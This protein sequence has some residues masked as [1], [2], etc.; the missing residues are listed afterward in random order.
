MGVKIQLLRASASEWTSKN[1]T[2][3]AGQPGF[4]IDTFK[5][6]I[7]NGVL[8]WN[9]LPYISGGFGGN[10]G[11]LEYEYDVTMY[12]DSTTTPSELYFNSLCNNIDFSSYFDDL[13]NNQY[14]VNLKVTSVN[15]SNTFLIA[16]CDNITKNSQF[17]DIDAF[18][19]SRSIKWIIDGGD[20]QYDSA[21]YINTNYT[22]SG[23]PTGS[24]S[25]TTLRNIS[26]P[27]NGGR[28][29]EQSQYWGS[30]DYVTLYKKSIWAMVAKGNTAT[31]P[32]TV[33]YG[34]NAGA[35]GDGDKDNGT[36]TNYNGY[37]A[38]YARLYG[39]D[40]T[41]TKLIITKTGTTPSYFI[42]NAND[43]ND[44]FFGASGISSDTIAVVVFY[45]S[46]NVNPSSLSDLQILFENFVDNVLSG[47]VVSQIK[48]NFYNNF[49]T[50]YGSVD[51][52]FWYENFEF[53]TGTNN[54]SAN[55][56]NS[57]GGSGSGASFEVLVNQ[58][59]NKYDITISVA[60][61]N[62][63]VDDIIK[64][65]GSG[66]GSPNGISPDEDIYIKVNS[67]DIN[68]GVDTF[69]TII[70]NEYG[71]INLTRLAES[72]GFR[73]FDNEKFYLNIDVAGLSLDII[74]TQIQDAF[75][76]SVVAGD[77]INLDYD[78]GNQTLTIEST[79]NTKILP[80]D[81]IIFDYDSG[82]DELT[83]KASNI[84]VP[85]LEDIL[86]E[87]IGVD[88][89]FDEEANT[90]TINNLHTEI[91]EL[92]K[93]PQGFVN[94]T[95][96]VITFDD[97][98]RTF[99]I[100]PTVSGGSYEIYIEGVKVVKNTIETIVLG[101]STALNYI[102]FDT[103]T[104]ALQTKTTGFDFDTD[105][106]IA[107]IHW[108][109]DINQSTFF[110]E[111]RH[112][113]RMDSVTH[114]WI[115]NTF[116]M[117]Y[118]SGLSIGGYTLLGDGSSNSHAQFDISDGVLY[119][120]D[121]IINITD[122]SGAGYFIQELN[123]IAYIP[124][125]YHSG[126][127]GQWVRDVATPYA[128]K[129]NA[130]RAQYNLNTAGTWTSP[131][132]INGR[133]FAMWIVA[134]NDIN[135][136][137]LA[138]VGQRQDGSLTSAE[139]NNTWSS[140]NL[141]NIPIN[142]IRPLYRLIFTSNNS[143]TNTPK[144]SLQSILDTR[145]A[146]QST[147][148]G[149]TQNDH[150]SL[151]GLADDDHAQYV[152]IDI[153][154]DISVAHNFNGGLN[155]NN[156]NGITTNGS[157]VLT[158]N[159]TGDVQV[160]A[161]T[162]RVGDANSTAIITTNG[163]G[164]LK[165][166]TNDDITSGNIIIE[167]G[168]NGN[169]N[170]TTQLAGTGNI[171]LKT[172][173]GTGASIIIEGTDINSNVNINA[174]GSGNIYTKTA[175]LFVGT[176]SSSAN[177]NSNGA[178][179]LVLNGN[180]GIANVIIEGTASNPNVNVNTGGN[181]SINLKTGLSG[182]GAN[183]II[184]GTVTNA[185]VNIGPIG[186]G[187][188]NAKGNSLIVGTGSVIANIYG[189]G[190]YNL[191]IGANSGSG[192]NIVLEGGATNDNVNVNAKGTGNINLSSGGNI[193]IEGSNAGNG[194]VNVN[195]LGTG[196]IYLKTRSGSGANL[197]I[198]GTTTN[199]NINI[200]T[201]G[202][203]S[204]YG[205]SNSLIIGTGAVSTNVYSNGAYNLLLAANS[206]TG[207]NIVLEGGATN[208]NVNVNAIGTGN[209][210]LK[211]RSG[212]GAN[213]VVEGTLTNANVNISALGSG[214]IYASTSNI[215]VGSG[216]AATNITSNGSYSLTLSGN[217]ISGGNIVLEG[218]STNSNVNINA[219][220]TGN[221]YAT[222]NTVVMGTSSA[223]ATLTTAVNASNFGLTITAN[224]SSSGSGN[225]IVEGGGTNSNV[226]INAKGTGNIYLKA[227]SGV[228]ASF[229]IEGT[230]TNSNINIKPL[231]SGNIYIGGGTAT[232]NIYGNGAYN[233][234]FAANS[235]SGANI[236]LEG[237]ATNDNVN[238][239]AIGTGNIYLNTRSGS[240]AN[241]VVEGTATNANVNISPLG[242]GNVYINTTAS[243]GI[244]AAV[245]TAPSMSGASAILNIVQISQAS[246]D[247]L[248]SYDSNT[249]YVIT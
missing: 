61:I 185:N 208:D 139:S 127:T 197:V 96:S 117:Q 84:T 220:G 225:I 209:I 38:G 187:N 180:T 87:G 216:S 242:T 72:D 161:D 14:T 54:G 102:H 27:Y 184:E 75:N 103:A 224:G 114:K 176:G 128:V 236:V 163:T 1:P 92:S 23:I 147:V 97:S 22:Y 93:E 116:G 90:V 49:N 115:H 221:I 237:G 69:S 2:L 181:G 119:Q 81:N 41:Y 138:I 182:V 212:N 192:G 21:N 201:L 171:N 50:L 16:S 196:N 39:D 99:T 210:Y 71:F 95:D 34:G 17:G 228:G 67:I 109:S 136:P 88:L 125:Y 106:P 155:T 235:N 151:F 44:D 168:T 172:K 206:N 191:T 218:G 31:M 10:D 113:I 63:I 43:T 78:G 183:V 42:D 20:D 233:L 120:E 18:W 222:A 11:P 48:D 207:A 6:K 244:G 76:T 15:D 190:A 179:N 152:H 8:N 129:Y 86:V 137:I 13:I 40:P 107:F 118:I 229:I 45:G 122:G 60:G 123:P 111:E 223:A 178:Y 85:N 33:F 189:S 135:D 57:Q 56:I 9:S 12:S 162:L 98:S 202:T 133:Y 145:V 37:Q 230:A 213:I 24:P 169:I 241:I 198:E 19:P 203:G 144:S 214:N 28:I 62:Y 100:Q 30:N 174:L 247:A 124:I 58:E 32:N 73:F 51:P 249:L 35:D 188:V 166:S 211:T 130:T 215:V 132:V 36:L 238:V 239:N 79:A 160:D 55:T 175:N 64:I 52:G 91:N 246:Y 82:N 205:K 146:I 26:I 243:G 240:G 25:S 173:S 126:S 47:S 153:I 89:E 245:K 7:G 108:N 5:L 94:R 65:P 148:S 149:V 77:G 68:G 80:G 154:R 53:F 143:Y 121:I 186:T 83:I 167:N 200:S 170:I 101:S 194:N 227:R 104:G 134:T 219:K 105:V 234:V 164:N 165:L 112:G 195:A 29:A 59:T 232:T 156:I 199:S 157:I 131:N 226:N 159:G 3:D 231:G 150:G 248:G 4:E 110:G 193:I 204:I 74:D 140:I 141:T 66:L 217:S 70:S 158:P 142:E 46:D 177:I